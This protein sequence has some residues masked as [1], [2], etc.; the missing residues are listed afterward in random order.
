MGYILG[1]MAHTWEL[2]AMRAFL[3]AFLAYSH[4]LTDAPGWMD[5]SVITAFA[6]F[7]GL[8]SSV[9]GNELSLKI[10]RQRSITI[11]ML[12]TFVVSCGIGFSADLPF[13]LVVAIASVYG[14]LITADS[15]SLTA[16]AVGSAPVDL[17]GATM[18]VHSFLGF[19]GGMLGPVVAGIV[20]D[21]AGGPNSTM[22]WGVM[23]AAV[24]LV[25]LA[26]PFALRLT[27]P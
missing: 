1:Y 4:T 8:P 13:M 9:L 7:L 10:G 20:L 23:F 2:V 26:G 12:L 25:S 14:I 15:S 21:M 27:R 22:G 19:S 17:R 16:G 18:A 3:L 11:I 5:V 24:G 6:V